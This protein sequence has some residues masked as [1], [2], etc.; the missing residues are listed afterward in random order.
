M[1]N[2][3]KY[4]S[5]LLVALLLCTSVNLTIS[6]G[7]ENPHSG[8]NLGTDYSI[9]YGLP[10]N[11]QAKSKAKE[12]LAE[13]RSIQERA[14]YAINLDGK[15]QIVGYYCGPAA[16][17]SA[18][19]H[20]GGNIPATTRNLNF[21]VANESS[22]NCPYPGVNHQHNAKYTSPQITLAD[23]LGTTYNGTSINNMLTVINKEQSRYSY[24]GSHL[25]DT[26]NSTN[27]ARLEKFITYSLDKDAPPILW[28]D[29]KY[30]AAYEKDGQGFGG[31]YICVTD[32]MTTS[33]EVG[34][35]DPNY[36]SK[37]K[38]YYGEDAKTVVSAI[39]CNSSSN[40]NVLW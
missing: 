18:V 39:W 27:V 22:S 9:S 40:T 14:V 26:M 25:D 30:L 24:N 20:L 31:H 29:A 28:V 23:K 11:E 5:S 12:R 17:L 8:I 3:Y 36:Y 6:A 2:F 35:F 37:I 16:A 21:F 1:K 38:D 7:G 15:E 34:I 10:T 13:S 32:Y 33:Q 19:E 4:S